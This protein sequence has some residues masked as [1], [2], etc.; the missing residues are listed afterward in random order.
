MLI[1]SS[2][3]VGEPVVGWSGCGVGEGH[4]W[5]EVNKRL[6][7]E[8]NQTDRKGSRGNKTLT[9]DE[10]WQMGWCKRIL[11]DIGTKRRRMKRGNWVNG[12]DSQTMQ[13]GTVCTL[14][15]SALIQLSLI[16]INW[17]V[18][19]L[20]HVDAECG[21]DKRRRVG[22]RREGK[23]KLTRRWLRWNICAIRSAWSVERAAPQLVVQLL[24]AIDTFCDLVENIWDYQMHNNECTPYPIAAQLSAGANDNPTPAHLPPFPY[25]PS[26]IG[27][28]LVVN[29]SKVARVASVFIS[30]PY[31]HLPFRCTAVSRLPHS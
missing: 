27:T 21:N 18:A 2:Q 25:L 6:K 16:D 31:L 9:K 10:Q 22:M 7:R 14:R 11:R 1:G 24:S 23:R 4:Y 19:K 3:F 5:N 30:I 29:N 20:R 12:A 28:W 15:I 8:N 26:S 17:R 13:C